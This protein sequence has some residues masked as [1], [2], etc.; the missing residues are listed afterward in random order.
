MTAKE[1]NKHN[2]TQW[3]NIVIKIK[4][5]MIKSLANWLKMVPFINKY[6]IVQGDLKMLQVCIGNY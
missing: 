4:I 5:A 1:S 6:C 3:Q 2:K